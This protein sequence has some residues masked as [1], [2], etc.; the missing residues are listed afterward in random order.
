MTPRRTVAGTLAA[1]LL[2]TGCAQSVDPIERMGRKAA[3]RV[4]HHHPAP[5]AAPPA[6]TAP[7][8]PPVV[9]H[10]PTR[11]KVVFLTYDLDGD[12]GRPTDPAF[13]AL[14]RDSHLPLTVF[15]AGPGRHDSLGRLRALGADLENR[16]FT[17]PA[18]PGLGYVEQ[19]TQICAQQNH[20]RSRFG[21]TPRLLRPPSGAYD[22][23]TLRAAAACGIKAIVLWTPDPTTLHPGAIIRTTP[24]KSLTGR[25]LREIRHQGYE[26]AALSDYL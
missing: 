23:T 15:T 13:L 25:L 7:T 17:H 5:A 2:L 16:T 26:V 11:D 1:A 19:H 24:S 3:Q 10:I 18:L 20:L 14:V 4:R 9:D 6:G 12:G 8:V 21:R 22:A